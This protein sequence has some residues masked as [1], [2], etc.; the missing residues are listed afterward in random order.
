MDAEPLGERSGWPISLHYQ[1]VS[2]NVLC[3]PYLAPKPY[4]IKPARWPCHC[5]REACNLCTFLPDQQNVYADNIRA[6]FTSPWQ[7]PSPQVGKFLGLPTDVTEELLLHALMQACCRGTAGRQCEHVTMHGFGRGASPA[8][9]KGWQ[10]HCSTGEL[11]L[12]A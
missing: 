11:Q 10:L 12:S 5:R 2:A 1:C 6:L 8:F 3:N 7:D 4:C 9:A